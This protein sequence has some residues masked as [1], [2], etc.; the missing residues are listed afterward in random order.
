MNEG[1]GNFFLKPNGIFILSNEAAGILSTETYAAPPNSPDYAAQSGSLLLVDGQ[2]NPGFNKTSENLFIRR[3]VGI[4]VQDKVVF[5]LGL[6]N[7]TVLCP[8]RWRADAKTLRIIYS[9]D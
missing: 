9:G 6:D 7:L 2:P 8:G 4:R 3:G 5:V 1:E